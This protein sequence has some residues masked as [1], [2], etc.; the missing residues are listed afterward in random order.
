MTYDTYIYMYIRYVQ[1]I[2]YQH[3]S[4]GVAQARPNYCNLVTMETK[5]HEIQITNYDNIL[6]TSDML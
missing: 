2:L 6:L 3:R 4:V 1:K 5:S